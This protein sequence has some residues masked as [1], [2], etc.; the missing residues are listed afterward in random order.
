MA[1]YAKCSRTQF[2]KKLCVTVHLVFID[3]LTNRSN[4]DLFFARWLIFHRQCSH[5]DAIW[6]SKAKE[7]ESISLR[8]CQIHGFIQVEHFI[9]WEQQQ[10]TIIKIVHVISSTLK[11]KP[12][13]DATL[14][15]NSKS[16]KSW[17][18]CAWTECTAAQTSL[19]IEY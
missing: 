16:S 5:T 19:V 7:F 3:A 9:Y 6:S 18:L 10:K 15:I 17:M 2:Q 14:Q 13:V 8:F 11:K 4:Y 1:I 12:K